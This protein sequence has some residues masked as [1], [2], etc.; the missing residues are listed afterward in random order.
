MLSEI[1]LVPSRGRLLMVGLDWSGGPLLKARLPLFPSHPRAT[2]T[3]L[4]GLALW[5]GRKLPVAVGANASSTRSI[6]V[7]LPDGP[8]WTSPLVELF[9]V[10]HP[11]RRA[12]SRLD[13]VG[14]CREAMQ[15]RLPMVLS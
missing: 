12:R 11:R 6:E 1:R 15:L 3:L 13:G 10:E 5:A 14:D 2:I 7:L 9:L 8:P 4:E